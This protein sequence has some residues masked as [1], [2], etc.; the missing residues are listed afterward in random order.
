MIKAHLLNGREHK[1]NIPYIPHDNFLG[2]ILIKVL[3]HHLTLQY[4]Y[5]FVTFK[6][7]THLF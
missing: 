1:L 7:K 2:K 3:Q 5:Y 6:Q 4:F